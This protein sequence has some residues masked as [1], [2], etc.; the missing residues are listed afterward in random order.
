LPAGLRSSQYRSTMRVKFSWGAAAAV[1]WEGS[2]AVLLPQAAS[3]KRANPNET[4]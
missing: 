4:A 2:G 3:P 1:A